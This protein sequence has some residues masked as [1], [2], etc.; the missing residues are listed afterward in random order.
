MPIAAGQQIDDFRTEVVSDDDRFCG[1]RASKQQFSRILNI[2]DSAYGYKE[3]PISMK[4]EKTTQFI[5]HRSRIQKLTPTQARTS[6]TKMQP[7]AHTPA[8]CN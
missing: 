2:V 8:T 7:H 5:K 1:E 4:E 3:K 6:L